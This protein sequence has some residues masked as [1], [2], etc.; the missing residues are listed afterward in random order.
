MNSPDDLDIDFIFEEFTSLSEVD[1]NSHYSIS[2]TWSHLG[3]GED[4]QLV[5][6][7]AAAGY[8]IEDDRNDPKTTVVAEFP[9]TGVKV[10]SDA[11]IVTGRK[12][13]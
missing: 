4:R 13:S 3:S 10:R 6:L 12:L 8:R 1:H 11:S 7:L 5:D 2:E 9:T